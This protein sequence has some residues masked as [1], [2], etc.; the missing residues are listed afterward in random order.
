[1]LLPRGEHFFIDTSFYV[2]AVLQHLGWNYSFNLTGHG[3]QTS[4]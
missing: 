3:G 4:V 1:M 2:T